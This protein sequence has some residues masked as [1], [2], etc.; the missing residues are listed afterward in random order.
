[1]VCSPNQGTTGYGSA[2]NTNTNYN[3]PNHSKICS[4]TTIDNATNA[5]IVT[6]DCVQVYCHV[7][8]Y[9]DCT[10]AKIDIDIT[11]TG[12]TTTIKWL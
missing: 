6:C 5:T 4:V 7:E 8:D 3:T 12:T 1:M 9:I 2:A 10:G 11:I